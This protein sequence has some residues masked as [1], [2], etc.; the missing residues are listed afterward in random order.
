M[1]FD[2]IDANA[3]KLVTV[4]VDEPPHAVNLFDINEASC[5]LGSRRGREKPEEQN[6]CHETRQE[7]PNIQAS[8][9]RFQW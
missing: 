1:R 4:S 6:Q 5:F 2:V 9:G 7:A 3:D 8:A